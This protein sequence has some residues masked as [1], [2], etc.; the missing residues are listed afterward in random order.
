MEVIE[1]GVASLALAG[2]T[3]SGDAHLVTT[4]P[5]GVLLAVV[6]GLGHGA[7]AAIAAQT[8]IETLKANAPESPILLL[9]RCHAAL[10]QT[11]GVALSLA[12]LQPASNTLT[13]L[14]VGNVECLL[15]RGN[16]EA[17]PTHESIVQRGGVVGYQLPPLQ[18]STI[19][20]APGDLLIFATDGIRSGFAE[21]L[22]VTDSPQALADQILDQHNRITDDALV[23]VVRYLGGQP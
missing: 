4:T 6:D 3:A 18:A 15:L 5:N 1:W 10:Q 14:G 19:S 12:Q 11:R 23:L 20:I 17:K 8:A 13:W 22:M 7:I 9:S 16:P 21:K 2:E